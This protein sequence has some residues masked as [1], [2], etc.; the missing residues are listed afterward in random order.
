MKKTNHIYL[1]GALALS[2]SLTSCENL[3]LNPIPE[4]VLTDLNAFSNAKDMELGVFGVYNALQSRVPTDYEL[5][6]I[7]SDNMYG[8]YFAVSPGM[9]A[10]NTLDVTSSNQKINSFWKANYNGIFRANMILS[11]MDV[12]T[13]FIGSKKAE[14]TA[15]AKFL[16]AMFYFDMVRIFGGVPKVT[17]V[18]GITS[19]ANLPRATEQEIY[20]LIIQDLTEATTNLPKTAVQGRASQAAAIGLL[21][22]VQ[23]FRE[24]W[25]AARILLEKLNSDFNYQLVPNY[26]DLFQLASEVNTEAIFSIAYVGGTNGQGLSYNLLPNG[27]VKGFSNGGNRVGRPTWDLHK[28]FNVND[29]RRMQTITENLISWAAPPG[30]EA[31]WY[32]YFSKW[33][34][35]APVS[36]S[37]G[38][39]IPLIRYADMILLYA[40]VLHKLGQNDKALVELN[41]V[42][43]RAF[44]STTYNY[45]TADVATPTAFMDKLL[46]ERRFELAVENSRW[47]D[48]V[49]T[50]R[51]VAKLQSIQAEYNPSTGQAVMVVRNALPHMKYFPI[52]LEQI[53]LSGKGVLKQNEGYD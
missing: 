29:T 36:T 5:M 23:V 31:F 18:L 44:K 26:G 50:G 34:V 21:A 3:L 37:S 39:D 41:K 49:R 7:P 51:F 53:Q 38:L 52:P 35:N 46:D 25:E 14:L 24:N 22:R 30:A 43:A 11:K 6:E 1:V 12:P 17:E 27:G 8:E 28:A 10:I 16:R 20:D 32:P 42:R 13:D 33:M 47:F 9:D 4:S 45:T 19:A 40:E 2:L 15:E 48:L